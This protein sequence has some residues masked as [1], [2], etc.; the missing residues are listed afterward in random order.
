MGFRWTPTTLASLAATF[1]ASSALLALPSATLHPAPHVCRT[2]WKGHP[3]PAPHVCRTPW[4]GHPLRSTRRTAAAPRAPT[5]ERLEPEPNDTKGSMEDAMQSATYYE[6]K[7]CP[8]AEAVVEMEICE[9]PEDDNFMVT[10]WHA[11]AVAATAAAATHV[12]ATH[13]AATTAAVTDIIRWPFSATCTSTRVRWR[14]T[15]RAVL[16]LSQSSRMPRREAS[17]RRWLALAIWESPN[18]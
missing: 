17:A 12:A 1:S 2:P 3:H 6:D 18:P 14:T 10:S 9:L 13:T 7:Y 8:P 4:K 11:V 15:T 5:S 16:T